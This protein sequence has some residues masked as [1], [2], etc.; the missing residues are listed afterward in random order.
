MM[1]ITFQIYLSI[2]RQKP[3]V[4]LDLIAR[5]LGATAMACLELAENG[6]G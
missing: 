6:W 1:F 2:D 4:A 5:D 3:V